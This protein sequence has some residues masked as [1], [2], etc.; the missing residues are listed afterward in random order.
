MRIL[1]ENRKAYFNYKILERFEAGISLLGQEVKSLRTRGLG[2]AGS[3]VV[4]RDGE[5]FWLGAN[6]PP[7]QPKNAPPD[8]EPERS[9]KLLL[10]KS[11]IKRL[12]GK[13]N[14]KGLTLIPLKLYTKN[15]KIKLEFASA[16]GMKR[17][18][19]R[20][21]IKK[22]EFQREKERLLKERG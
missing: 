15:G 8:Y 21:K 13:A 10:R 11:E 2:L 19:K 3:Y 9:R 14:Q 18:D 6:I 20:E 7:Y 22:R 5:V 17:F 12:I 16:K 1:S 4:L